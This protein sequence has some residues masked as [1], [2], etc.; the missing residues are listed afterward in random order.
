LLGN[1]LTCAVDFANNV[2]IAFRAGSGPYVS[3]GSCFTPV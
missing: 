2:G 1:A 3:T